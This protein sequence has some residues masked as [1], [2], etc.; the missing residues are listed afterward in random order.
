MSL[1]GGTFYS[2]DRGT[3]I[4]VGD[5]RADYGAKSAHSALESPQSTTIRDFLINPTLAGEFFGVL[6]GSITLDNTGNDFDYKLYLGY[7][8]LSENGLY[9][10]V[11]CSEC[12][13]VF[14][15]GLY[16]IWALG[17]VVS[18]LFENGLYLITGCCGGG[19]G[20]GVANV[21]F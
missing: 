7:S 19:V 18:K 5:I 13:K 15:C 17:V 3:F 16:C 12:W 1:V 11:E 4:I 14:E 20:A 6:A 10:G 2:V 9:V 21:G 8:N